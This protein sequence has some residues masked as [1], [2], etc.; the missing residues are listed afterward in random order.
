M[1]ET[2]QARVV[3][4]RDERAALEA[5][6]TKQDL[7][8]KVSDWVEIAKAQ[9][10]GASRLVLGG[11]ASGDHLARVLFEDC[12]ADE[13][14]RIVS[15]PDSSWTASARSP[16]ARSPSGSRRSTRRSRGPKRSFGR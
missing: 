8:R 16:I 9:A 4:L 7:V 13:G 6:K 12:L 10:A 1:S 5:T 15:S 14:W 3:E 2:L 11:H